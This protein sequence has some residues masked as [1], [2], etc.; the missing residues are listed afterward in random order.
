MPPKTSFVLGLLLLGFLVT[1]AGPS[2]ASAGNITEYIGVDDGAP[3]TGPFPA[4]SNSQSMFTSSAS[5]IG[6]LNT[7]TFEELPVG[8]QSSFVAAPGVTV[9]VNAPNLGSGISGINNFTLGN[10]N[11]FN[12][13]PGG[14]QWFGFPQGS[15]TFTFS[16]GTQ[17]FGVWL[18]G[19]QAANLSALNM[20]FNDGQAESLLMPINTNGGAAFFGFTDPGS[21]ISA[22][23]ITGVG[24]DAWGIDNVI[25]NLPPRLALPEPSSLLL[26]TSGAAALAGIARRK[27]RHRP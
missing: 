17:S 5:G 3:V 19:V 18:T 8:F 14:D 20:T 7:I 6:T 12:I 23:T 16:A 11:G 15:A 26:L 27:L 24:T 2:S 25:Y 13:T 10:T 4:S 22:I 1:I 21:N 9:T